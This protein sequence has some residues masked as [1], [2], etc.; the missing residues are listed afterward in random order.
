[1]TSVR[2]PLRAWF[3]LALGAVVAALA[4]SATAARA[5]WSTPQ[6]VASAAPL[7]L[8]GGPVTALGGVVAVDSRGDVAVAWSQT[9]QRPAEYQG[10]R[11]SWGPGK[12]APKRLGC[13]PVTTVH[14]TLELASGRV[15]T[16]TLWSSRDGAE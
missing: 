10:L 9:G 11:C 5:D 4:V 3:A 13:Y 6:M 2:I 16:R 8:G 1:M 7:Q 15:V 14:L 12:P